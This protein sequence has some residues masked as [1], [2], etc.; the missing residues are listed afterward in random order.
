MLVRCNQK[1][2]VHRTQCQHKDGLVYQMQPRRKI[3]G[4]FLKHPLGWEKKLIQD[5]KMTRQF[6]MC[7]QNLI[8]IIIASISSSVI[9]YNMSPGR[10]FRMCWQNEII[11]VSMS[12]FVITYNISS[13][14]QYR[15]CWQNLIIITSMSLFVI[16]YNISP[17][18]PFNIC[19]FCLVRCVENAKIKVDITWKY[20][21]FFKSTFC[22]N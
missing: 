8:A 1:H 11:I 14:R 3:D 22:L 13:D 21:T 5:F 12:L 10:Q 17:G 15:M 9:T 2:I 7:R 6:R 16:T 4:I 19:N 18:R 20:N